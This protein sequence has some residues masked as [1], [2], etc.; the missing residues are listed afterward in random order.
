METQDQLQQ[1]RKREGGE[2]QEQQQTKVANLSP[3]CIAIPMVLNPAGL[4]FLLVYINT[5]VYSLGHYAGKES[6]QIP[7]NS[8]AT[9]KP[10]I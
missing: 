7:F 4:T 9:S 6:G 1:D 10:R 3:L 2:K 8:I 5:V